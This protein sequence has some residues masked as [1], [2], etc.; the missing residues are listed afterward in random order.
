M[1][2]QDFHD[3]GIFCFEEKID[4]LNH[5]ITEDKEYSLIVRPDG[6]YVL[7]KQT[8]KDVYD[9]V[10]TYFHSFEECESHIE[11]ENTTTK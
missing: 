1:T 7:Y 9:W 11:K 8:E 5:Y 6:F 2:K 10:E 4:G 3:T